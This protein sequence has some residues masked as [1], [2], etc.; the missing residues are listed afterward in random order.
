MKDVTGIAEK[1]AQ[2]HVV[3]CMEKLKEVGRQDERKDKRHRHDA[4]KGTRV[5]HERQRR[6]DGHEERHTDEDGA[7][8]S[9]KTRRTQARP[10]YRLHNRNP[11]PHPQ[12]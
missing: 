3:F 12:P 8:G 9:E 4:T 11:V 2:E 7:I 5:R 10:E 1:Q 6:H